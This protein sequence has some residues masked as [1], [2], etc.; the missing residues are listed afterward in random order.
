ML[1]GTTDKHRKFHPLSLS[2]C[3]NETFVENGYVCRAL[4]KSLSDIYGYQYKP[5][6]LIAD[7]ADAITNGFKQA[8]NYSP[9]NDFTRIMCWAHLCRIIKKDSEKLLQGTK[10]LFTTNGDRINNNYINCYYD[11]WHDFDEVIL[12]MKTL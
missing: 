6:I 12:Y 9:D 7:D 10:Y 11:R 1:I 2:V 3:R 4:T 8:F 5:S